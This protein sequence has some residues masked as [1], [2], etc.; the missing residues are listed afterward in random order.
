MNKAN[1]VSQNNNQYLF[2][3]ALIV[4]LF[5]MWGVANNLNDILI[6]QFKKAFELNDLQ[7]GLV[8]SAFYF[9]YFVFA[10]P[11]ALAMRRYGYKN[12]IIFG[13]IIY[14]LGAFLFYPAAEKGSYNF[15]LFALFIIASGLAFLETTANPYVISL[16]KPE[17]AAWRLNLAQAF[18]PLGSIVGVFIGR[19]FILS[20]VEYNADELSKLSPQAQDAFY[21][22][23]RLAVQTPYLILGMIVLIWSLIIFLTKFPTVKIED[24]N[25]RSDKSA[26]FKG[27]KQFPHLYLGA[28]AQFS[29]VGAQVGIWSYLIRY[30]QHTVPGMPEKIAA[31]Y[32]TY[33][34]FAFMIGRFV[35][36]V[37]IKYVAAHKLMALFAVVNVVLM[38]FAIFMDGYLGLYCLVAASFFMS[39]MY[40]TIFALSIDGLGPY[41]KSGSSLIVMAIIGGAILTALMGYVSDVST[42]KYAFMVPMICFAFVFYFALWGKKIGRA[43]F[44][45]KPSATARS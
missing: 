33:A 43:N 38:I 17:T 26:G 21:L 22:S 36:T 35:G 30:A 25:A 24:D 8:Q 1:P 9:G 44:S 14:A 19:E 2:A 45:Y 40:P 16:G 27:L 31:D 20:G 39:V 37:L 3:L 41:A 6:K 42:I 34:I 12:I 23:E 13:L 11:A 7:S 4:S 10:M 18:N 5:F 29:Y 15:F 32:L 28:V